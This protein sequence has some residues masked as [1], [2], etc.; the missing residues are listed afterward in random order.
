VALA[1]EENHQRQSWESVQFSRFI[2]D[3]EKGVSCELPKFA[4]GI[5]LLKLVRSRSSC[6]DV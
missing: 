3:L 4:D 6:E 5:K 2:C 1:A